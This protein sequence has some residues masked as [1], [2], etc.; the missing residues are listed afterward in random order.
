MR[1]AHS[2]TSATQTNRRRPRAGDRSGYIPRRVDDARA[3]RDAARALTYG[4]LAAVETHLHGAAA[5]LD[6]AR[7]LVERLVDI[8]ELLLHLAEGQE[9][10][11][12]G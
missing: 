10:D 11:A 5:N 2:E 7:R 4:Y 6:Q 8:E 1:R 12:D 3:R 9:G